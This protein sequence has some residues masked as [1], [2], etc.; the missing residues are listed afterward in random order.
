LGKTNQSDPCGTKASFDAI[1]TE[2]EVNPEEFLDALQFLEDC[3]L[4]KGSVI[5]GCYICERDC[6]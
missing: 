3:Q 6:H 2:L 5:G 4:A 1:I